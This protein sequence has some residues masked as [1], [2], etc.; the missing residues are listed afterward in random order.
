MRAKVQLP[1]ATALVTGAGSG[2]GRATALALARQGTNVLAVDIDEASAKTTAVTCIDIGAQA[3]AHTCDVA[4]RPAMMALADQIHREHGP[5]DI[6]VNNAG[7]GHTGRFLDMQPDDWDWIRSINLDGVVHGCQA[8][9]PAMLERRRGHVVNVSSGLAYGPLAMTAAYSTT[10]AGVLMFSRA[11]RPDW[12]TRGLGVSVICPGVINTAI[13]EKT[14]FSGA[15]D[16]ERAQ[17][18]AKLAF[19]FGHRPELVADAIVKAIRRNKAIV[20]VGIE[21]RAAWYAVK[22]TPQ[23][24]LGLIGR[25]LPEFVG[26][27][28]GRR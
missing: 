17:S 20:P 2:I 5:L 8:F 27:A 19:R 18:F 3:S 4:D 6:L 9:V 21:S 23:P 12:G 11:V 7:V 1:G 16:D 13:I 28:L 26:R 15:V 24:V 25:P 22:I 10:K 14:R